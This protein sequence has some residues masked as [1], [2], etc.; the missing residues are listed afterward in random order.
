M[1]SEVLQLLLLP[2]SRHALPELYLQ[3]H[4]HIFSLS[5]RRLTASRDDHPSCLTA[6]KALTLP[7]ARPLYPVY[8]VERKIGDQLH[9]TLTWPVLS[10]WPTDPAELDRKNQAHLALPGANPHYVD[11]KANVYADVNWNTDDHVSGEGP[12]EQLHNLIQLINENNVKHLAQL[13]RTGRW[14]RSF[15]DDVFLAVALHKSNAELAL[16]LDLGATE[17]DQWLTQACQIFFDHH[18]KVASGPNDPNRLPT[19][20]QLATWKEMIKEF[21]K[22][23]EDPTSEAFRRLACCGDGVIDE[24]FDAV[25]GITVA[26]DSS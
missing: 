14:P 12:L 25:K 20:Q 2:K 24:V 6:T 21:R 1:A 5:P 11:S 4:T 3:R 7:H 22:Q 8:Q 26:E 16:F 13:A 19:D 15:A 18:V 23:H 9:Y 10:G 17:V